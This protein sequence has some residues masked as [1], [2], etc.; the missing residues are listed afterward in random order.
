MPPSEISVDPPRFQFKAD[1]GQRG[2]SDKLKDARVYDDEQGGTLA[3]WRDPADGK[4]YVVN[5]HHRLD[6]ANR[7]N[8]PEV[9]VRYLRANTAQEARLKGAIINIGED[10]GSSLDAAKVFRDSGKSVEELANDGLVMKGRI[11][12][13]GLG[14]S[15]LA[16]P[17]FNDV[18]SGDL[19]P[20]RG[21]VIGNGVPGHADQQALYDL[22]QQREKAGK[23]P[24]NDQIDELI[25]LTN[26]TSTVTE[27]TGDAEQ[28]GLF[29]AEEMTRS[30]LP[31]K[32]E[33]SDY[34]RKQLAAEKKLFGAVSTD[35]AAERLGEGGNVIKA[36]ENKQVAERANQ[37]IVLYDKLST[38]AGA[39]DTA[40]D[41]AAKS[42][43]DGEYPVR[44]NSEPTEKSAP[45]S[46]DK[47]A[48]SPEMVKG[49]ASEL[50]ECVRN[51]T[52]KL[53]PGNEIRWTPDELQ[54]MTPDERARCAPNQK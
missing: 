29:G 22:I 18:V 28:G 19:S 31:E 24:T 8:A 13:E 1:V 40:L 52:V 20:V 21:A 10:Q 50:K 11:A 5:G 42:I 49:A 43:A 26:R 7:L 23:R 14:I 4:T 27:N 36:G 46:P 48:Y 34:V 35:A 12:N 9:T 30:L 38:K 44:S 45:R 39:I 16:P 2:V 6:L 37:G 54:A 51:G 53:A 32:A 33:V 17:I 41:R 3:V 25:R 47:P 15:K